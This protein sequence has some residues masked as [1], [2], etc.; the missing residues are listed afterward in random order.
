MTQRGFTLVEVLV[1]VAL[2]ALGTASV[3]FAMRDGDATRLERDGQRLAALL[4]AARAQS[5]ASGV[6]VRWRPQGNSFVFEGLPGAPLPTGWLN[7]DTLSL[8]TQTVTLGPDPIVAP[9][10][11]TL[12]QGGQAQ[13]TGARVDVVSDGLRPFHVETRMESR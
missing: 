11:I 13:T 1:V 12:G 3:S 7:T 9:A 5:R 6:A 2:I 10:R 8:G 4:E